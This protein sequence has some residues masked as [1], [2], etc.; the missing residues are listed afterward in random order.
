[1]KKALAIGTE[2]E[3]STVRLQGLN[4]KVGD[5]QVHLDATNARVQRQLK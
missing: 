1:L 2:A 4:N 3:T 5:V